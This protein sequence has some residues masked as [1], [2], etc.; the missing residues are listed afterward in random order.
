MQKPNPSA[1]SDFGFAARPSL[2]VAISSG[3]RRRVLQGQPLESSRIPQPQCCLNVPERRAVNDPPTAPG[4]PVT[5]VLASQSTPSTVDAPQSVS[6][7]IYHSYLSERRG[8]RSPTWLS[9][10]GRAGGGGG[11][12]GVRGRPPARI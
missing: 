8:G 12:K 5:A 10:G 4:K 1:I 6:N 7:A 9:E 11:K 2:L 3:N